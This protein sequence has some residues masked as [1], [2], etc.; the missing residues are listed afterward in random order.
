MKFSLMQGENGVKIVLFTPLYK[1]CLQQ[2]YNV[3][4]SNGAMLI[5]ALPFHLNYISTC[6]NITI[7]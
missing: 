3:V 7:Q 1:G 5:K 2:V 6:A 4:L